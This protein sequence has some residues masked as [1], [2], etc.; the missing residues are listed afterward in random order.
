MLKNV[1]IFLKY[2]L[3]F[4]V[5]KCY[6]FRVKHYVYIGINSSIKLKS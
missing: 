3:T 2:N 1:T 4:I 6:K 5:N